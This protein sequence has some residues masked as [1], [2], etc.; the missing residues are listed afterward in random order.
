MLRRLYIA[1]P[2]T[3]YPAFNYPAFEAAEAALREVGYAV[4]N[5]AHIGVHPSWTHADYLRV[6]LRWL[7]NSAQGV[8][9]LPGWEHSPGAQVE[10]QLARGLDLPVAPLATWLGRAAGYAKEGIADGDGIWV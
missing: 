8:A 4:L 9:V 6:G 10:T 7:L 2:M 3:G 5:P 1:G